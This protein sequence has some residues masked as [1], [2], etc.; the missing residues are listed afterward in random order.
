MPLRFVYNMLSYTLG[1]AFVFFGLSAL[2]VRFTRSCKPPVTASMTSDT[3]MSV[4]PYALSS[5]PFFFAS[6]PKLNIVTPSV[7][8]NTCAY[9][10]AVNVR[11]PSTNPPIITGTIL[12]DLPST[13][14]G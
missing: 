9:C 11:P 4:N 7:M 6:A 10:A 12:Q 14:V 8:K 3:P 2:V 1:L 13:C 5:P